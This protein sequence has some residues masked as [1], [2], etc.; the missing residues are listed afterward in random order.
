MERA[1]HTHATEACSSMDLWDEHGGA[2]GIAVAPL[3]FPTATL[4]FFFVYLMLRNLPQTPATA[5]REGY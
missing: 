1:A 2:V 4:D 5:S 3:L